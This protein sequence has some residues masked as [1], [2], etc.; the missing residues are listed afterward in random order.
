MRAIDPGGR[1]RGEVERAPLANRLEL[2]PG[3]GAAHFQGRVVVEDVVA[4]VIQRGLRVRG[5][6]LGGVLDLLPH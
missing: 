4:Q 5:G 1:E 2:A 6:K 3:V